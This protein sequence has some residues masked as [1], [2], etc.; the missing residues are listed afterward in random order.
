MEYIAW[1]EKYNVRCANVNL[2]RGRVERL[3]GAEESRKREKEGKIYLKWRERRVFKLRYAFSE[4]AP[5]KYTLAEISKNSMISLE[6]VRQIELN[7]IRKI[8]TMLNE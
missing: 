5:Y 4:Y 7:A 8:N 1:G 2:I 3:L 6:R